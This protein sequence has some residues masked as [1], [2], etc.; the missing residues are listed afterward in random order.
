M[1]VAAAAV[2]LAAPALAGDPVQTTVAKPGGKFRDAVSSHIAEDA[3]KRFRLRTKNPTGSEITATLNGD[4]GNN[5]KVKWFKGKQNITA[6][7]M[8][9]GYEF[10]LDAGAKKNFRVKVTAENTKLSCVA[11]EGSGPEGGTVALIFVN[12]KPSSACVV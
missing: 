9:D 4:P 6:Q 8:G 5:T 2:A 3:T 11:S 12:P 10:Q 1:I 7:V